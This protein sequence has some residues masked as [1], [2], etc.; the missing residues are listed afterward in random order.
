MEHTRQLG[1]RRFVLVS[2]VAL[3]SA[4]ASAH[5]AQE[6]GAFRQLT[7]ASWY[8]NDFLGKR[9]ASG[10]LF[11]PREL[12]AAHRTLDLGSMVRVTDVSTG[13]SVVVQ[14]TDRGP[15][16]PGRG[17]DLSYAAARAL[18]IVHRG[19]AKVRVELVDRNERTASPPIVTAISGPT[20]AWLP[21]ALVK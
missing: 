18:G 16:L 11:N 19:V 9:M 4:I 7:R 15:Y 5:G 20:L 17:I 21:K 10:K 14:I 3:L 2:L 6:R 12:T 8:G 13:R 1:L